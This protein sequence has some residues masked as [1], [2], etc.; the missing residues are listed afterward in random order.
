MF[1]LNLHHHTSVND[2]RTDETDIRS[3]QYVPLYS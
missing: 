2:I 1:P 3:L